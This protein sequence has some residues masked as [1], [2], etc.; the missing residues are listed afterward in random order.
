MESELWRRVYRLVMDLGKHQKPKG[1]TYSDAE[2]VVTYLWGVLNDRPQSWACQRENWPLCY[3]R[4]RLPSQSRVSRR[5]KTP[6]VQALLDRIQQVGVD[7]SQPV[8]CKFIDAK[9]LSVSRVSKDKDAKFGRA[10]GGFANGYKLYAIVDN[11]HR[12]YDWRVQPM[13][14]SEGAMARELIPSLHGEGYLIGDNIY[15][16]TRLYDI[17][18]EHGHQLVAPRKKPNTG[19]RMGYLSPA[20][21]RSA[22]ILEGFQRDFGKGLLNLRRSIERFFGNLTSYGPGL[23]PLPAWVRTLTR[24]TRWVQAK[25][26]FNQIRIQ[27]INPKAA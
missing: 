11:F 15:D 3:R 8:L 13:N 17:A 4:R 14:V 24:V 21:L 19:F 25:I 9:P 23:K 22:Q 16:D 2:I 7:H 26:I 27:I 6:S 5:L 18:S 12:I 20:R 1:S 10:E